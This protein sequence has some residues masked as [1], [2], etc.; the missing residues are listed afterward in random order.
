[1]AAE[2]R[3]LVMRA[4]RLLG[5]NLVECNLIK[6]EQLEGANEVLLERMSSGDNRRSTLL[7]ILAFE[8]KVLREEDVLQHVVDEHGLGLIDL[9]RYDINDELKRTLDLDACWASWTVPFDKEENF[10]SLATAYYLSPAVRAYWEK[11]FE[12]TVLWYG[13]TLEG[14]ADCLEKLAGPT[15]PPAAPKPAPT[16]LP[17]KGGSTPP[18]PP[19]SSTASGLRKT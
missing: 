11:Q 2:H 13:T 1:M 8:L 12:G 19:S 16:N 18:S 5:A 14:I 15:T 9:S 10:Y 4:N 6:I 3:P 7:G 17:T